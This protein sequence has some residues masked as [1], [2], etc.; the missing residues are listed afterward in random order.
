MVR[1]VASDHFAALKHPTPGL[2][3]N[4][5]LSCRNVEKLEIT[6]ERMNLESDT[7][8]DFKRNVKNT[9]T[10]RGEEH[11]KAFVYDLERTATLTH[12]MCA[13]S[14]N[15]HDYSITG[16][17]H[18]TQHEPT[19]HYN[20]MPSPARS[21][22]C[23]TTCFKADDNSAGSKSRRASLLD[24]VESSGEDGEK[25]LSTIKKVAKSGISELYT[26]L[27][28]PS[29]SLVSFSADHPSVG[30][31]IES[32]TDVM[33]RRKENLKSPVNDK[34][35]I[36]NTIVTK[37]TA[38]DTPSLT[39]SLSECNGKQEN[40]F[41]D[42]DGSHHAY[43][44][45]E[46]EASSPS[47]NQDAGTYRLDRLDEQLSGSTEEN[48]VYPAPIP[49]SLRLPE[50]LSQTPL[51]STN[52]LRRSRAMD[53]IVPGPTISSSKVGNSNRET[54]LISPENTSEDAAR[55]PGGSRNSVAV[56]KLP[57]QLRASAFFDQNPGHTTFRST[58]ESAVKNLDCLLEA[59]VHA[60][61]DAFIH[62]AVSD[63]NH[64][65]ASKEKGST[66]VTRQNQESTTNTLMKAK[67]LRQTLMFLKRKS[68]D[69]GVNIPQEDQSSGPSTETD[70]SG[71]DRSTI[72]DAK[73]LPVDEEC[74][75]RFEEGLDDDQNVC[76]QA[77]FEGAPSTLLAELQKRKE[78]LQ[79]RTRTAQV[80]SS[81]G[82][83][84]T[85]LQLDAVAQIEKQQRIGQRVR[86]A[87]EE[88][89]VRVANGEDDMDDEDIP[90]GVLF[91]NQSRG[92]IG[93]KRKV[94]DWKRPLGLIQSKDL[95]DNEPLSARRS[96]LYGTIHGESINPLPV[97]NSFPRPFIYHSSA[98]DSDDDSE[99]LAKRL[100]RL[101]ESKGAKSASVEVDDQKSSERYINGSS[102][103]LVLNEARKP[104]PSLVAIPNVRTSDDD[105]DD[106]ET[107]G[108]R[109]KRLQAN[110]YASIRR[111][112][113]HSAIG[114]GM[115]KIEIPLKKTR[116]M[117]ELLRAPSSS[118]FRR[119]SND[120]LNASLASGSL[121]QQNETRQSKHRSSIH[122]YNN[123]QS[124]TKETPVSHTQRIRT[125]SLTGA[126]QQVRRNGKAD[127]TAFVSGRSLSTAMDSV[128]CRGL[129]DISRDY[130]IKIAEPCRAPSPSELK[131]FHC[132]PANRSG[133]G[134]EISSFDDLQA[135]ASSQRLP[136]LGFDGPSCSSAILA[137][138]VQRN[139][140]Y[141][142]MLDV[143]SEIQPANVIDLK[144]NP[145][146]NM[147]AAELSLNSKQQNMIQ[148]W[149]Q[150]VV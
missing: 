25:Y 69:K 48:V 132:D 12:E 122:E 53:I 45:E 112:S 55:L 107:L 56:G 76:S 106:D 65:K 4:Q 36:R 41:L 40:P 138:A 143:N 54:R 22:N 97:H 141:S 74:N 79:K 92:S 139:P 58:G 114:P 99:T 62:H 13:V 90:L 15:S 137:S 104:S 51:D 26:S 1:T 148:R 50:R 8:K 24:D 63:W 94:S 87:W 5:S 88:P 126:M 147:I 44:E 9:E 28:S 71:P 140:S 49:R 39:V 10:S 64:N 46:G 82:M 98:S 27:S 61:A 75:Y 19:S 23:N 136:N 103:K 91:P 14:R 110:A 73:A 128:V 150:S 60:P 144:G 105:D 149:Q 113:E 86:L 16:V 102:S 42:F 78:Q 52:N 117:V 145:T 124:Y 127:S 125:P 35:D 7:R 72:E 68:N 119:V 29:A 31:A 120:E 118:I 109:R 133:L 37:G 80:A 67:G 134:N 33:E 89:D 59:S 38:S 32:G 30:S 3:S 121:L 70:E 81:N 17:D 85:L 135:P 131:A 84:T 11:F 142:P 43:A 57:P 111:S 116:S 95:E 2:Q 146:E 6:A 77:V 20:S 96:R 100:Q 101:R 18:N 66:N 115:R 123:R 34:S 21:L 83:H 130:M 108:Q 93:G 129:P 47:N